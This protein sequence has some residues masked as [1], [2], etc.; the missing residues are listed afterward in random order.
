[1]KKTVFTVAICL[2]LGELASGGVI[3]TCPA[4]DSMKCYNVESDGFKITVF[5]GSGDSTII[6]ENIY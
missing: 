6:K 3:I 5:K 2:L 4:G 1:M